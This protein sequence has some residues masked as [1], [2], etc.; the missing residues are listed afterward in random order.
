MKAQYAWKYVAEN[1]GESLSEDQWEK[2][3]AA[4][5]AAVDLLSPQRRAVYELRYKEGLSLEEIAQKLQLSRNTVRNHLA[6]AMKII[7]AYMQQHVDFYV[8][9]WFCYNFCIK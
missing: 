3:I 9:C 1:A 5:H 4:L 7:R 8:F 6:E 2:L